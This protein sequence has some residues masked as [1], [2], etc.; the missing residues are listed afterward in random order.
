MNKNKNK[1]FWKS[2]KLCYS[3][4]RS[5]LI[6]YYSKSGDEK[7]GSAVYDIVLF[8]YYT[9]NVYLLQY[10]KLVGFSLCQKKISFYFS[11]QHCIREN[12]CLSSTAL[13]DSASVWRSILSG[14]HFWKSGI[15]VYLEDCFVCKVIFLYNHII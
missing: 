14:I 6:C 15:F 4:K 5:C 3:L 12:Y 1:S 11:L 8:L 13:K 2:L 10:L 7:W 9:D